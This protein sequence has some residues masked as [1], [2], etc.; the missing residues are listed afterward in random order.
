MLHY[1]V[2]KVPCLVLLKPGGQSHV[3]LGLRS[4]MVFPSPLT[5]G[6]SGLAVARTGPPTGLQHAMESLKCLVELAK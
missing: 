3:P 6:A 2:E 5:H 4:S 1:Q